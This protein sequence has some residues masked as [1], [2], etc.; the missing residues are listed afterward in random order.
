MSAATLAAGRVQGRPPHRPEP[1]PTPNPSPSTRVPSGVH[2]IRI[3]VVA[4]DVRVR[5]SLG[6][7]IAADDRLT[8]AG[9]ARTGEEARRTLTLAPASVDLVLSNTSDQYTT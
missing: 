1:R 6:V 8:L 3:F 7:L 4:H 5:A 9:T 2:P